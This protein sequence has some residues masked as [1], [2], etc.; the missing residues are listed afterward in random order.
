MQIGSSA[1]TEPALRR[2]GNRLPRLKR[3]KVDATLGQ[4][5]SEAVLGKPM[6]SSDSDTIDRPSKS[7]SKTWIIAVA[8]VAILAVGG[9]GYWWKVSHKLGLRQ[10]VPSL[11]AAPTAL[12]VNPSTS[13]TPAGTTPA[14]ANSQPSNNSAA[15]G[16][17]FV[18]SVPNGG[19]GN[20]LAA[21]TDKAPATVAAHRPTVLPSEKISAPVAHGNNS[22][23]ATMA[24]P[25]VVGKTPGTQVAALNTILP[26]MGQPSAA[27]APPSRPSGP[28]PAASVL[29]QPKLIFSESPVYPKIAKTRGDWGDVMVDALVSETGKVIDAKVISGPDTLQQSALQ[30]VRTQTY[31]PAKLNGKAV[32]AHVTVKIPFAKPH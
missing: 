26:G 23:T 1:G 31:Q 5:A 27:P 11:A 19:A 8:A 30:V 10:Q 2:I 15:S 12:P 3:E 21:K 13:T 4:I 24:A 9:G 18:T 25:D 28:L 6:F 7:G 29:Q 17:K 32:S 16:S 14:G 22:S 20:A